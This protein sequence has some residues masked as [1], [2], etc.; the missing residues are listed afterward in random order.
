LTTAV[1]SYLL[2]TKVYLDNIAKSNSIVCALI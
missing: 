2:T 1:R